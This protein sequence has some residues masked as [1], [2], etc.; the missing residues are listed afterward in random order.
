[1]IILGLIL[2]VIGLVASIPILTTIGGILLV[3]GLI[4]A[5]LGRA[6]RSVGGRKHFF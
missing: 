2:L 5:I 3:V 1:M 6:G 4:L